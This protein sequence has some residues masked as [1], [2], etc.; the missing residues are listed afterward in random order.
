MLIDRSLQPRDPIRLRAETLS[1]QP[2]QPLQPRQLGEE[3]KPVRAMRPA[4]G[5]DRPDVE[6]RIAELLGRFQFS[7]ELTLKNTGLG[8]I[9][10]RWSFSPEPHAQSQVKAG[11]ATRYKFSEL[12]K[13]VGAPVAKVQG[14]VTSTTFGMQA[15]KSDAAESLRK[16]NEFKSGSTASK[17]RT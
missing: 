1:A 8:S 4:S 13:R 17:C 9:D 6:S 3:R 16:A 15:A 10:T 7:D 2:A 12:P 14:I 11:D 5:E